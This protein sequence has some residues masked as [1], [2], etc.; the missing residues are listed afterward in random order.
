MR[1][2]DEG[3]SGARLH[4]VLCEALDQTYAG[5]EANPET[6]FG[7]IWIGCLHDAF[8]REYPDPSISVF[9]RERA[10]SGLAEKWKLQEYLHDICVVEIE[11]HS[12]AYAK[13]A[14]VPREVPV[15][16]RLIWQC[17]SEVALDGTELAL[18]LGKLV[19]GSAENK[20]LIAALP[21]EKRPLQD[22]ITFIEKAAKFVPGEFFLATIP[23]Y[24]KGHQAWKG[25][26]AAIHLYRRQDTDSSLR[27]TD[28]I[29][30]VSRLQ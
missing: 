12:A 10:S 20:L 9:S 15:V 29:A 18:D 23:T 1:K 21:S 19:A 6:P 17:E 3:C 2:E 30:P 26:A 28:I 27:C 8:K 4:R 16:V 14:A 13:L 11:K 22:W 7:R 5:V 25:R 24:A